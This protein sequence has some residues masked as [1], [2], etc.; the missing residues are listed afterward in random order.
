MIKKLILLTIFSYG[1][2]ACAMYDE[3]P[4]LRLDGEELEVLPGNETMRDPRNNNRVRLEDAITARDIGAIE[5]ALD[6]NVGDR[7]HKFLKAGIR[8]NDVGVVAALAN[9]LNCAYIE[10][11]TNQTCLHHVAG[12]NISNGGDI[13]RHLFDRPGVEN[14]INSV[15]SKRQTPWMIALRK[16]NNAVLEVLR[17]FGALEPVEP[18]RRRIES[19][20][21]KAKKSSG[22]GFTTFIKYFTLSTTVVG[23][24]YFLYKWL[25]QEEEKPKENEAVQA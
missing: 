15:D 6:G 21:K 10:P 2:I 1:A 11:G 20:K 7:H 8:T 24:A 17:E 3:Q 4:R 25:N 22:S 18:E 5:A 19:K 13:A 12:V 9:R 14:I 23:G 16:N